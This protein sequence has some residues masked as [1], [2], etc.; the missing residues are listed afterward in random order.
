MLS[1][2]LKELELNGLVERKVH[3]T[4]PVLIEYHL[5]ASGKD[6]TNVIDAMIDWGVRHRKQVIRP[7]TV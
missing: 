6:I 4:T 1:K 7:V 3:D 5:T 2:E